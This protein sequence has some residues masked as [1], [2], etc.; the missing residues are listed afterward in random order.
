MQVYV[1]MEDGVEKD[2]VRSYGGIDYFENNEV[3][4]LRDQRI[5]NKRVKGCSLCISDPL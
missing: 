3:N 5:A 1:Y 2:V 4:C